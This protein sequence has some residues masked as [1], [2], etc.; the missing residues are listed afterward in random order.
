MRVTD[1]FL[2]MPLLVVLILVR[3]PPDASA[4]AHTLDG[5]RREHPG[6]RHRSSSL[7][8]WMPIARIVRGIVLSLKEK[9]FVEAARAARQPTIGA[10]SRS[11]SCPNCAGA[12]VVNVTLTVAAAILTESALSFLGFGVEPGP[13][14]TWGNLLTD[15]QG[16]LRHRPVARL[17]PRVSRSCSRCSRVNFIGD[18]LRDALDPPAEDRLMVGHDCRVRRALGT[19]PPHG[20]PVLEI[21]DLHVTFH[22]EDG[23]VHAVRGVDLE[24]T[25]ARCSASWG[26]RGRASR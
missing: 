23:P 15:T 16:L 13:S 14:P 17:V 26:S 20:E 12:I 1:L 25:P 21:R 18:G 11:T 3:Q 8:F 5:R 10:S 7:F 6:D 9:E 19:A 22:T 2:A 24:S 4:W